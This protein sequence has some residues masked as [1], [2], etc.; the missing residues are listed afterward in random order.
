MSEQ[1][2]KSVNDDCRPGDIIRNGLN[3][4][5]I[6]RILGSEPIPLKNRPQFGKPVDLTPEEPKEAGGSP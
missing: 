3:H 2:P 4:S 6:G 1:K 5:A